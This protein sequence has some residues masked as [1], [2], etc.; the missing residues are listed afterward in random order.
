MAES[1]ATLQDAIAN[2]FRPE[3]IGSCYFNLSIRPEDD[4]DNDGI[5]TFTGTS[6]GGGSNEGPLWV[7]IDGS[8]AYYQLYLPLPPV[9]IRFNSADINNDASV[10]LSDT[11]L[12]ISDKTKQ[13][14][15]DWDRVGPAYR[16]WCPAM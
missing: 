11:A 15:L 5:L 2:G 6:W 10:N 1:V 16:L 3:L 9:A 7:Q 14:R 13:I 8:P 4:A 12:V